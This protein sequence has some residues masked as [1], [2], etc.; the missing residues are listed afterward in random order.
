M[1]K[2][3]ILLSFL[4]TLSS[5]S[6]TCFGVAFTDQEQNLSDYIFRYYPAQSLIDAN[7]TSAGVINVL[8]LRKL[9]KG[10][11]AYLCTHAYT[12]T[13]DLYRVRE[14]SHVF[15]WDYVVDPMGLH[16]PDS[17]F[18]YG[19]SGFM[20]GFLFIFGMALILIRGGKK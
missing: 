4:Y 9:D 18:L 19:L 3:L 14:M 17:R 13:S 11:F 7:I 1:K 8:S 15:N 16:L 5:A 20:M 10:N 2:S 12:S 6:A